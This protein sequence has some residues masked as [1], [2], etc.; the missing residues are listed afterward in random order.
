MDT[1]PP[2]TTIPPLPSGSSASV[3]TAGWAVGA[4]RGGAWWS[5]GW[6]YFTLSPVIWIVIGLCVI[7]VI[8][9]IASMLLHPALTA[10]LMLGCRAQDRGGELTVGHLFAGFGE[11]RRHPRRAPE[12]RHD[13][14]RLR[15]AVGTEPGRARR[16]TGRAAARRSA[17]DGDLVCAGARRS[18]RRRAV[19]GDEDQLQRVPAQRPAVPRLRPRRTVAGDPRDDSAGPGLVR[20]GARLCG[21]H[22]RGIQGHLRRSGVD[23]KKILNH[24]GHRESV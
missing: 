21:E 12:R 16:A 2:A 20:A 13:A 19:R 22:L 5:E 18:A 15:N 9:Q 17:A 23:R 4:G 24:R 6:R 10:G 3:P 8:G 7:P 14:G 11:R 1:P